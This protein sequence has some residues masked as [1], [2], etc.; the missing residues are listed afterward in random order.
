MIIYFILVFYL[1]NNNNTGD[2]DFTK[3]FSHPQAHGARITRRVWRVYTVR[4]YQPSTTTTEPHVFYYIYIYNIILFFMSY[5]YYYYQQAAPSLDL[6]PIMKD[7]TVS[8]NY[9][10][11]VKPDRPLRLVVVVTVGR[12]PL[13]DYWI[14]FV[15]FLWVFYPQGHILS[16][17]R[18]ISYLYLYFINYLQLI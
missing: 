15:I 17:P 14:F 10:F 8:D 4:T 6:K 3:C 5:H 2:L 16:S 18:S 1:N 7:F 9:P 12:A 13:L 11:S